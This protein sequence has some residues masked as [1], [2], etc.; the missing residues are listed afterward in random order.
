MWLF[1][2]LSELRSFA[3]LSVALCCYILFGVLWFGVFGAVLF[4]ADVCYRVWFCLSDCVGVLWCY[5]VMF[6]LFAVFGSSF[7]FCWFV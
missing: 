7:L 5:F 1:L 2:G 3:L 4:C 6:V